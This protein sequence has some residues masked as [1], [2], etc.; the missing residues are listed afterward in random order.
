LVAA[1][2]R[3]A[4]RIA[5]V[6]AKGSGKSTCAAVF[7][8]HLAA[9][10]L[11]VLAVDAA[12]DRRLSAL[13]GGAPPS[14]TA[15][16]LRADRP[17]G[18]PG[19]VRGGP[20]GPASGGARPVLVV[21]PDGVGPVD[22]APTGPSTPA[23]D[24]VRLVATDA[25]EA[26]LDHLADG[27]GEYVVVDLEAEGTAATRYDLTVLVAEPMRRAVGLYRLHA[28]HA[29]A[30]DAALLVL[31]NKTSDGGDAAWLTE[32]LGDAL[33]GCVGHSAWVRAAERGTAGS[34]SG[35]EPGNTAALAAVR[36]ALDARPR[37][38]QQGGPKPGHPAEVVR[39]YSASRR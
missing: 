26:L 38:L 22:G 16:H 8:R 11:P 5:F 21:G 29:A 30:E 6:G 25:H 4:M 19:D 37:K 1:A 2:Y 13:L 20:A 24:G 18:A 27:P 31:G 14:W 3:R 17:R 15:E 32:E 34:V 7:S 33:L 28:E 36:S 9:K 35:F 10:G 39:A 12:A 23:A